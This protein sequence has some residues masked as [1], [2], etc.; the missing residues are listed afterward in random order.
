MKLKNKSYYCIDGITLT[1]ET[2]ECG[3]TLFRVVDGTNW[4]MMNYC[5]GD[6]SDVSS[7]REKEGCS[8][9]DAREDK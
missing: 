7:Q 4:P 5:E 9:V 3:Q 6:K 2:I 1:K 8:P